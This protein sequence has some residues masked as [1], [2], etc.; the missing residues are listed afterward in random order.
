[1]GLLRWLSRLLL[2]LPLLSL[3]STLGAC[4]EELVLTPL[5]DDALELHNGARLVDGLANIARS[6]RRVL[7]RVQ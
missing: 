5:T 6:S 1:M 7:T 3:F 4:E 2:L